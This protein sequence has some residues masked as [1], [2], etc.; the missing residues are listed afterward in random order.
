MP[1]ETHTTTDHGEI[2]RWAA[3]RGGR[4]AAVEGTASGGDPG[5]LRIAFPGAPQSRDESLEEI[6]W[7]DFFEK[8]EEK[9]L[10]FLYQNEMRSGKES[11]FFKFVSRD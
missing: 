5:V 6:S 11:R 3:A 9:D 1:G 10:A 4:P 2:R 7:D 8:F